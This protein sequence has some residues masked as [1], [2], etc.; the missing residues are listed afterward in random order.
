V[1]LHFLQTYELF[2]KI[3]GIFSNFEDDLPR[4]RFCGTKIAAGPYRE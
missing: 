2:L 3:G 4:A 1:L